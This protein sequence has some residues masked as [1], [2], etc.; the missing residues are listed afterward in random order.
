MQRLDT[1]LH[2]TTRPPNDRFAIRAEAAGGP[3]VPMAP[4]EKDGMIKEL[5]AVAV[6]LYDPDEWKPVHILE[7]FHEGWDYGARPDGM[8]GR[9]PHWGWR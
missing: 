3:H 5:R 4:D 2:A 7:T 6:S 8:L 1:E 9:S